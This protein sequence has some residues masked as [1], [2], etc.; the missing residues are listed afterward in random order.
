ME[1]LFKMFTGIIS[2]VASI[3]SI[4]KNNLSA[5]FSIQLDE[6]EE[7]PVLGESIAVNG[8]CMTVSS[9]QSKL[10]PSFDVS[11]ESL[12]ITSIGD[13]KIYHDREKLGLCFKWYRYL[14]KTHKNELRLCI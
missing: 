3:V 9:L 14:H 7:A 4:R 12:N 5:V 6:K 8:A 1:N 11:L 13:L 2:S 10:L